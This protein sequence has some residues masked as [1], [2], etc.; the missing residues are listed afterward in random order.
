M[1]MTSRRLLTIVLL[2]VPGVPLVVLGVFGCNVDATTA[3]GYQG[4]IETERPAVERQ[5]RP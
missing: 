5:L 4:L 3:L 1:A 2:V